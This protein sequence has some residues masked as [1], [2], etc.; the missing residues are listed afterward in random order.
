MINQLQVLTKEYLDHPWI[1]GWNKKF[2]DVKFVD[3]WENVSSK[4]IVVCGADVTQRHV[5]HWLNHQQPAVYVGRGYCGNH[6][7]KRR[8]WWRASVNGWANTILKPIPYSRWQ[9]FN[10]PKH[11]WKVQQVNKVLIAPSAIATSAWEKIDSQTWAENLLDK[12]PGAEVKI[13][14]KDETQGLRYATLWND[15]DWC[16]LVVTQSSAISCEAFWYGKKVISLQP[17]PTWAAERTTLDNWQDPNEPKH[18][19]A[20][21]EHLAWNQFSVDE[22]ASGEAFDLMQQYLGPIQSYN[23]QYNYNLPT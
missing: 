14:F 1:P 4:E 23:P 19:E 13:R 11:S 2:S 7:F 16:D 21:H 10:L 15:L 20:W 3:N 12:F 6:I 9:L 22:W 17:C 18:R 5:K 8:K